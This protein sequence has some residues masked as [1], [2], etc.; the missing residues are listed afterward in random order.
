MKQPKITIKREWNA[1]H[2]RATCI[3]NR[4]YTCGDNEAYNNMLE[5]VRDLEPTPENIYRVAKD[6]YEHSRNQ[7][8]TNI[9][10]I[11]EKE[12]VNTFYFIDGSDEI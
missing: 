7:T 9:M 12:A 3:R 8:I 1:G 11:L 4:L 6:I 5:S 10:F 2:V